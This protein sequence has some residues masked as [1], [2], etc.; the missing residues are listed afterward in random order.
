MGVRRPEQA[1]SR[2]G[3]PNFLWTY[4]KP[5]T[6]WPPVKQRRRQDQKPALPEPQGMSMPCSLN[7]AD[8]ST[9]KS[10]WECSVTR[11]PVPTP[12]KP[13]TPPSRPWT[14]N[15]ME[16]STPPPSRP[17]S[18]PKPT[19]STPKNSKTCSESPPLTETSW[20][21]K[22]WPTLSPTVKP[23]SKFNL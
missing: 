19:N 1:E 7:L 11:S 14:Q 16:P 18:V 12:K 17:S 5:K 3:P 6:K 8:Q 10:S 23:T 9:S 20:T 21:T 22:D 2:A 4:L 13:S 15:Q